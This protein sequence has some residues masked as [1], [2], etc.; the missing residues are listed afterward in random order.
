MA[1]IR[2]INMTIWANNA[3]NWAPVWCDISKSSRLLLM[4]YLA[5]Q[6]LSFSMEYRL[7]Y[8]YDHRI[9]YHQPPS[10]LDHHHEHGFTLSTGETAGHVVRFGTRIWS[11]YY[12]D[13]SV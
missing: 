9:V 6:N 12:L 8:W 5:H 10:L 7:G 11:S 4:G 3:I 2:G 13:R 1:L